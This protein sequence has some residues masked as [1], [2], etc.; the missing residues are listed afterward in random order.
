MA[1]L[2]DM[3]I[4]KTG[5]LIRASVMLGAHAATED[6]TGD[7]LHKLDHYAKCIGLAFQIQDDI[8][9][10]E[11][12]TQAL[13]KAQGADQARNKPTYPSLLGLEG[14]K[15]RA[16]ELRENALDSLTALGE[17][18]QPLRWLADYIVHRSH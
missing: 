17:C 7:K 8:L 13:G 6:I 11:A 12:P 16:A 4:H 10:I 18:A 3:H 15:Q 5:A 2:E 9:D 14:A 1:Q